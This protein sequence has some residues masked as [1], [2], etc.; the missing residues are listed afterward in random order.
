MG[1]LFL[2]A[3]RRMSSRDR[4]IAHAAKSA[5]RI[6]VDD[7]AARAIIKQGRSLLPSGVLA[8]FGEFK[9]GDTVTIIDAG[10]QIARGL[11]NYSSGDV[12][13]I[14]RLKTSQ[15]LKTLGSKPADEI[16][17]RNNLIIQ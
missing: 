17:H 3:K 12:D 6:V 7:G 11:S 13:R 2:P 15:I 14:K 4:W 1:T 10:N 8:V 5:G 16:I 9:K